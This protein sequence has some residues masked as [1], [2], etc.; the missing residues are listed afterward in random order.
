[1]LKFRVEDMSK[2]A[3]IAKEILIE[4]KDDPSYAELLENR[5]PG[6]AAT[7]V[8]A[9]MI[10]A[11][12][13][14]H[15]RRS[16]RKRDASPKRSKNFELSGPINVQVQ[17][18]VPAGSSIRRSFEND[19]ESNVA[20]SFT[21]T[22]VARAKFVCDALENVTVVESAAPGPGQWLKS[23]EGGWHSL[24]SLNPLRTK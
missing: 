3:D 15:K 22:G 21:K 19:D 16:E 20:L 8:V 7:K 24:S 14:T 13:E 2:I 12:E 23:G 1:M 10:V 11:Y 4:N 18:A 5:T 6:Q 9:E 17:L